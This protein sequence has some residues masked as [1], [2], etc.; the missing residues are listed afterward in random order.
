MEKKKQFLISF[1][2]YALF[3]LLA[4]CGVKY[5][6]PV[7]MPFLLAFGIVLLLRGPAR[8]IAQRTGGTERIWTLLLLLIFY[9]LLFG[10][11]LLF[12]IKSVSS[13]G[14]FFQRLPE[15]YRGT[16]LPALNQFFAWAG[17]RAAQ[18][19]PELVDVLETASHEMTLSLSQMISSISTVAFNSVSGLL[20]R[21]PTLIINTILMVV[22]SFYL[23][24][25]YHRIS[26]SVINLVPE[27]WMRLLHEVQGKLKYSL[28]IYARSYLLIFFITWG[29]L[30]LGL[31]LLR[32]PYP[33][34]I[35]L[36]IAVCDILPVLGTGT[37]LIPWALI[38]ALLGYYPMVAGVGVLYLVITIIRNFIEPK[39]VGAQIGLHP[40]LTLVSMIVGANLF[41]IL[42]LFGLPVALSILVQLRQ[43]KHGSEHPEGREKAHAE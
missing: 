21:M 37:V 28:G 8:Q 30:F 26:I 20:M 16:L 27:K 5:A 34:P 4:Y 15:L 32:I 40:L 10:L 11:I 38:A 18:F 1:A 14:G 6:L 7:L 19:D 33:F 35:S 39:L 22:S 13:A 36:M 23:A 41:G 17:E 25:D 43:D 3:A 42:G 29:E 24:S 2:Y 9:L 12:G 31:L